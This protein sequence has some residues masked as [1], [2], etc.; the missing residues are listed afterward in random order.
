MTEVRKKTLNH[1][2]LWLGAAVVLVALFFIIRNFTRE[3]LPIRVGEATRS[4]LVSTISTNGKVEP[5]NDFSAHSPIAATVKAIYVHE[6]DKVSGGQLLIALD[7]TEARSRLATAMSGLRAAQANYDAVMK[8]GTQEERLSLSA[9][10]N[11]AKLDRDQAQRDLAT[12]RKLQL[13][14]SA[15]ASEVSGAQLRLQSANDTLASLSKRQTSRFSPEDITR[16][17]AALAEAQAAYAAAQQVINQCNV[18][19]QFSGTVYS[20]PVGKTEFVEQGKELIKMADLNNVRV[21]AYFDEPEIGKLQ[22]GQPIVVSW[23]AKPGK[24]W[25]GHIARVPSTIITY[26]TRNVGEVMVAVDDSD[27]MLLPNTNV[28]VRVTTAQDNNILSVP[29]EALHS[30]GGKAYVYTVSGEKIRRT[31][32]TVGTTNLTQAGIISGLKEN[33]VVALG[34]TNGTSLTDGA[35]IRIVK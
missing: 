32:V 8:G 15:S 29:R 17:K 12:L 26:G 23:D 22:I 6:G 33:D 35:P 20:V 14:G 19:A 28:T 11:K 3:R 34:T 27:G 21:R 2:I 25:R 30:E 13:S 10:I 7:D 4:N 18:H 9:D 5:E 31:S 16:T 24:V 1:R